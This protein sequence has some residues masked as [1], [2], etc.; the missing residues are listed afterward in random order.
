VS[1]IVAVPCAVVSALAYG[2]AT[3]V[4][5]DAAHS[6]PAGA[7]GLVSL[8]RNPRWLLA[9]GGNTL[10]LT[11]QV[12]ALATGPVV[13]VQPILVLALPISL[14]IAALLGGPRP[15]RR[16]YR[17][18][19]VILVALAGFFALVGDP[20]D[21]TSLSSAQVLVAAACVVASGAVVLGGAARAGGSARSALFG[22][23]AGAWFGFVAVLMDAAA[24]AWRSE[25]ITVFAHPRGW[26]PVVVL[27]AIGAAS[28]ALTQ[29]AF[30][31][32][33]LGASLP[34]NLVLDPLVAIV[35]GALL[36]H[37]AVPRSAG[38]LIAYVLCLAAI[39]YGAV[40]LAEPGP[41]PENEHA[42]DVMR[43]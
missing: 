30:Q 42:M 10:G 28:M 41:H 1:L 39:V 5:H 8:L 19:A 22:A 29:V 40:R 25:G 35:L 27:L 33:S 26:L 38:Y 14:P 6:A 23:V 43:P 12:L 18:C 16:E 2:A 31:M 17:S 7:A 20:G 21:A 15:R 24:A 11:F 37:E 3:A 13:L 9:M 34:A 36:L 32:G 4:E